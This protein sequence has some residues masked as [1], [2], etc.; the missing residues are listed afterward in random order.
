MKVIDTHAHLDEL[1]NLEQALDRAAK[2]GVSTIIAVSIDLNSCKKTLAIAETYSRESLK[3]YPALGVHPS[4]AL[5]ENVEEALEYVSENSKRIVAVGEVGLDFW[6]KEARRNEEV[7]RRQENVFCR[8][9]EL[10]KNHSKPVLIHSRGAWERAYELVKGY[11]VEKAVFHWFSGPESVLKDILDSGYYISATPAAEYS[12]AH[13]EA[14]MKTPLERIV[15]ETDCPVRYKDEESEPIF[16][17]KTLRAVAEIKEVED[18]EVAKQTT[19]NALHI[20]EL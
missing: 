13:R 19:K 8:F 2:A 17:L 9:L 18:V 12:K 20:F 15:L 6:L 7:R 10:A 3:V 1:N 16:V 5:E 11:D 4:S 14:V